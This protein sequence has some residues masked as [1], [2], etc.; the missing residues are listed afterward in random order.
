[1]FGEPYY[2]WLIALGIICAI[3]TTAVVFHDFYPHRKTATIIVAAVAGLVVLLGIGAWTEHAWNQANQQ[4]AVEAFHV[5][6]SGGRFVTTATRQNRIS[7]MAVVYGGDS[8]TIQISPIDL[9][10]FITVENTQTVPATVQGYSLENG[11]TA[12]GPRTALCPVTLVGGQA[13]LVV[14]RLAAS[15]FDF[16]KSLELEL[17][18]K[19]ISEHM[20]VSGRTVWEC[21]SSLARCDGQFLRFTV[22]DAAG[23][24]SKTILPPNSANLQELS[25]SP[26]IMIRPNNI[27]LLENRKLIL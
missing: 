27:L 21:P 9:A 25:Q 1:L 10:I 18:G 16:S 2:G 26:F 6:T 22:N 12:D 14:S 17:I 3:V 8:Q 15:R 19:Q 5:T 4:P 11:Q 23:Q 7:E 24:T 13:I 20:T